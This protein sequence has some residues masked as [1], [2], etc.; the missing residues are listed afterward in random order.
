[1]IEER[2][3]LAALMR[4][5]SVEPCDCHGAEGDDRCSACLVNDALPVLAAAV[6]RLEKIDG[7]A[8]IDAVGM[9]AK[10]NARLRARLGR[11]L[12]LLQEF[13]DASTD[14]A[15]CQAADCF[16]C[17]CRAA[18]AEPAGE[19]GGDTCADCG[20]EY[21]V[22][23]RVPNEIWAMIAPNKSTLGPYIEHQYG[24]IL[25]VEC[26]AGRARNL[27]LRLLFVAE[28]A[29]ERKEEKDG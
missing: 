3:A 10:E 7:G 14:H 22:V 11:C 2:E 27:G 24:G 15:G 23:Y 28:P 17:R 18:L 20:R 19:D 21:R 25:C 4:A 5:T 8:Y 1:M 13:V 12:P 6:G 9:A 26:A 16:V 29:G